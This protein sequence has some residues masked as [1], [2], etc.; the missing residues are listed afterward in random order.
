MSEYSAN[1]RQDE[2]GT[3]SVN[4]DDNEDLFDDP[5]NLDDSEVIIFFINKILR[6]GF[7]FF[8]IRK[9]VDL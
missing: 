3:E 2:Y 5:Y 8:L 9:I 4:G 6:L 7:V 1:V